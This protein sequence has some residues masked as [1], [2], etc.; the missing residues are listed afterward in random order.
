MGAGANI[1]QIKGG[2]GGSIGMIKGVGM[3]SGTGDLPKSHIKKDPT[4]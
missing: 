3:I 1:G 2:Q 4:K